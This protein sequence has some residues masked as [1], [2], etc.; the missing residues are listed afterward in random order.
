MKIIQRRYEDDGYDV[1]IDG[2]RVY[3]IPRK[4]ECQHI[5]MNDDENNGEDNENNT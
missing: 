4:Q 5:L 1:Y 3:K 2:A